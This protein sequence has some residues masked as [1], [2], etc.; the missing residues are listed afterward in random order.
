MPNISVI[1][2]MYKVEKYLE[3]CLNSIAKQTYGDFECICID[4]GSPDRCAMIAEEYSARDSRFRLI[5]QENRGLAGARNTG[6]E[7]AVSDYISFVDADDFLH[8]KALEIFIKT[9][10]DNDADYV[11]AFFSIVEEDADLRCFIYKALQKD[12][13]YN[14]VSSNPLIYWL[15]NCL[16][17]NVTAWPRVYSTKLLNNIRFDNEMRIHEDIYFCPLTLGRSKRAVF[18]NEPLYYYRQ[19]NGSLTKSDSFCNSLRALAHNMEL[20]AKLSN[21]LG[22]SEKHKDILLKYCGVNYFAI[23]ATNLVLNQKIPFDEWKTQFFTA[24]GIFKK[25]KRQGHFK[26]SM[27]EGTPNRISLFLAYELRNP[28]LFRIFY[29]V[30]WP[31]R[32]HIRSIKKH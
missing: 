13:S 25:L 18:L 6:I 5:S 17:H 32:W 1:V 23:V 11:S 26:H 15:D 3:A 29:R 24:R 22:L 21:E 27:V 19:R 20:V 28:L 14:V 10:L 7:N 8:I 31:S 9:A 16:Y 12:L 4:D 30:L 2:P